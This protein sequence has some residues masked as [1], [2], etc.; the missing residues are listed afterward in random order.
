M[1]IQN[2]YSLNSLML[3]VLIACVTGCK[4]EPSYS[5]NKESVTLTSSGTFQLSIEG[6]V[7]GNF[8]YVSDNSLIAEIDAN[9][10]IKGKR[11]GETTIKVSG[12]NFSGA[13]KVTISPLYN[14]FKEPITSFGISKSEVKAKET[15]TLLSEV[16]TAML[17]KGNTEEK[18]AMYVFENG[19]LTSS[20][21]VLSSSYSSVLGSYI[22][23][24]YVIVSLSP[25]LGYSIDKKFAV[26]VE[27]QSSLDW[28]VI[29]FPYTITA[30]KA[31]LITSK[32]LQFK[33]LLKQM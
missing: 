31:S 5:L 10:L 27:L 33:S 18:Y 9:G 28:W 14:T 13:C 32:S 25:I 24:R 3:I 8:T 29:Y 4:K 1:K 17:F 16:E 19:K 30:G 15:R 12:N 21:I 22:A 20:L 11:V 7:T 26:G 23:E 2:L 6:G